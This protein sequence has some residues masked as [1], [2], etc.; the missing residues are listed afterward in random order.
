MTNPEMRCA[1]TMLGVP[2]FHAEVEE[3]ARQAELRITRNERVNTVLLLRFAADKLARGE[4]A[5]IEE[6]FDFVLDG[7]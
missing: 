6:T 5:S 1:S 3:S 7:I 4:F 2:N